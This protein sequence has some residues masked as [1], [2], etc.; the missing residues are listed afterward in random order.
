MEPSKLGLDFPR[1][2]KLITISVCLQWAF[3]GWGQGLGPV[4]ARLLF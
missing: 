4:M 3:K 2:V 1:M